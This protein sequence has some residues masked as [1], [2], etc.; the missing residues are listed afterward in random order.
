MMSTIP[1]CFF[2]S[3]MPTQTNQMPFIYNNVPAMES[4]HSK[5]KFSPEE[6]EKLTFIVSQYGESNWKRIAEQMGTRN[7]RQ[8]RERWKNYLSPKVC[9]E[10]WTHAEDQ[11]LQEKY[12]ELGSQWSVIAKYFPSR[13]DVNIKNRW[14]V[15]TN[16]TVQE[17]RV[18][19]KGHQMPT[20]AS[21]LGAPISSE[22]QNTDLIRKSIVDLPKMGSSTKIE[23]SMNKI[24]SDQSPPEFPM[25][26]DLSSDLFNLSVSLFND[27]DEANNFYDGYSDVD[28]FNF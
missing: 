10:P 15:L 11:L 16:H 18:R 8:C 2:S 14:V 19:R 17:K 3:I 21:D 7:C 25:K 6:D 9:K 26:D 23:G 27:N 4:K 28:L 12:K 22:A 24:S 5:R 20:H 1:M 13:T